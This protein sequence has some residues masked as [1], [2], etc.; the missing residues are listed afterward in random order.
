MTDHGQASA[1]DFTATH[2]KLVILAHW[3]TALVLVGVFAL[4][5]S[6][7]LIEEKAL[8]TLL[9][10]GHRALGITVWVF[11]ISR[12]LLRSVLPMAT[13]TPALPWWQKRIS[14]SSHV[15]MYAVLLAMPVL[16]WLLTNARGQVIDLPLLNALPAL[17]DRDLDL[18]DELESWHAL[19]A[20][21][22]VSLVCAHGAAAAWHHWVMRDGVLTAMWPGL[23][24]RV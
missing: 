11:A 21:A 15:L 6:R 2:P 3:A 20:W 5:L 8:R 23:R 16:G 14:Q 4:V 7:E 24:R 18:A 17:L 12:L 1:S 9:L 13:K 22:L 10:Q 19:L